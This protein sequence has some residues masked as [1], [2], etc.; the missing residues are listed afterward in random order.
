MKKRKF[1]LVLFAILGSVFAARY[2]LFHFG[3]QMDVR[4]RPWAYSNDP[5]KPLLVGKWTGSCQDPDGAVHE[6]ALVIVPPLTDEERWHKLGKRRGKRNYRPKGNFDGTAVLKAS[7]KSESCTIWGAIDPPDGNRIQLQISPVDDN[8]KRPAGFNV[9][10]L[11]GIWNGDALEVTV[12][13]VYIQ[14]D[15][16]SFW[17]SDDP[18]HNF[19]GRLVMR[20]R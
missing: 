8:A 12:E 7:G 3:K 4:Q 18:R 11:E 13:F 5:T 1:L 16:S 6:V 14:P 9:R 17:N 2:G 15:G 19:K 20:R 10:A